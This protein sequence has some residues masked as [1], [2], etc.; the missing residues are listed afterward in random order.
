MSALFRDFLN[1]MVDFSVNNFDNHTE[2]R[3]YGQRIISKTNKNSTGTGN[4]SC[5]KCSAG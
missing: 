2:K 5:G 3:Q 4:Y 1:C